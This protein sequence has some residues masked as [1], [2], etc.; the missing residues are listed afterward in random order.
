MFCRQRSR[1]SNDLQNRRHLR[2]TEMFNY[3]ERTMHIISDIDSVNVN[4][5]RRVT[6]AAP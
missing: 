2:A 5:T 3:I 6:T 4:V 1:R